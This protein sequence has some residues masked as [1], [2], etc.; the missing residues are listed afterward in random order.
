L[1]R[2]ALTVGA[3]FAVLAGVFIWRG[4]TLVAA[5]LGAVAALLILGGIAIPGRLGPVYRA[6]M[7][8]ALAISKVTTPIVM[9]VLYFVVLTPTGVLRR[10]LGG[11]P[12]RR[13]PAEPTYWVS[14]EQTRSDL[15]RQF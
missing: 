7:G 9:G 11:N 12:V 3:A 2:F 15:T 6:W 4:H 5:V 13:P 14:R 10:Y 8:F 1:R